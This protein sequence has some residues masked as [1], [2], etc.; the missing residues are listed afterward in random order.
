LQHPQGSQIE[1]PIPSLGA[2]EVMPVPLELTANKAGRLSVTA[3]LTGTG[4]E[5]RTAEAVVEVREAA[6]AAPAPAP[7]A[8]TKSPEVHPT[9]APVTPP[10]PAPA[11]PPVKPADAPRG[12]PATLPELPMSAP[13][14]LPL[15]PQS[16]DI[17]PQ[18]VLASA[19][20][21]AVRLDLADAEPA[22]EVGH[23]T[24]YEIR[25]LNQGTTPTRDV[26]VQALLPDEMALVTADG[27]G[28]Q[29]VEVRGRNV[30]FGPLPSL[31]GQGR[32]VY[33]VR[34]KALRPGDGRF[35]ARLQCGEMSRPLSQEVNT[36]VY[37]DESQ[38]AGL[39]QK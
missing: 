15:P 18:R 7:P 39:M 32:A 11:T 9:P 17:R 37:S 12:T 19:G 36:R 21:S 14:E 30:A 22:L 28:G 34:V 16:L 13:P 3:T 31:D 5:P 29:P 25:V 26:L 4:I 23:E 2:G 1:A 38:A 10:S 20:G 24:T 33:R 27:P 35:T 8:A 6:A